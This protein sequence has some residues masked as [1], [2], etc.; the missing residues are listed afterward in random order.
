MLMSN[1]TDTTPRKLP[2]LLA[3]LVAG[4]C[5]LVAATANAALIPIP[6]PPSVLLGALPGQ[7]N[8]AFIFFESFEVL[9]GPLAVDITGPGFYDINSPG[10]PGVIA[11]G[12]R[13]LSYMIHHESPHEDIVSVT[14]G[15]IFPNTILGIMFEDATLNASDAVLGDPGTLYPTGLDFRGFE[16]TTF[17]IL[18]DAILWSGDRTV[19]VRSNSRRLVDQLR[20][21]TA[22]PVPVP[23]TIWL[24]I[25]AGAGLI[26]S[27]Y[28]SLRRQS[29]LASFRL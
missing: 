25:I 19:F 27:R 4:C 7:N 29:M 12:T 11:Q 16:L 21:V 8:N 17:P 24:A 28:R 6:A 5:Q 1:S 23:G 2:W 15:W 26:F 13:V 9:S 20:I 14:G 3:L 22:V 10:V 18:P